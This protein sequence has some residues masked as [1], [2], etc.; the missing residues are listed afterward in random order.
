MKNFEHA[1]IL[2][3][4]I[5]ANDDEILFPAFYPVSKFLAHVDLYGLYKYSY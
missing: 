1:N 3:N 5:F 4:H 2:A